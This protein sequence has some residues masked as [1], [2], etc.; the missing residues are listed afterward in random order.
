MNQSFR[1]SSALKDIIGRDLI[2]ND[3]VAIFELVKNSFD[4]HADRVDIAFTGDKI[5]IADNGK[6]MASQ[7][8][9]DR[10]LFVAYS[11][12][13]SGEEDEGLPQD[14][15]DRIS[16]RPGYAGSKGIGRF[17]CDRLGSSLKLYSRPYGS[18]GKVAL[19]DVR[20]ADF[21]NDAK[22]PFGEIPVNLND[23]AHFPSYSGL[24]N[25]K[26]GTILQIDDLRD[27]WDR[28][29]LLKLKSYL[30]KLINPFGVQSDMQIVFH[31]ES[32]LAEDE[33]QLE[34]IDLPDD[35]KAMYSTAREALAHLPVSLAGV[36]NGPVGNL[37]FEALETKTTKLSVRI[38]PEGKVASRLV[39]RGRLI[40]E[41]EE[42]N[43]F[44]LLTGAEIAVDLFYLNRAAK[45]SFK[46]S[47]GVESVGFGN[48][49]LFLNGFRIFPVGEPADDTF[50]LNVRKAQGHSRYLGT[51]EILGRLDI[52]APAEMFRETSSRDAGLI[53]TPRVQA[54]M[55][56]FRRYALVRLERYV[57]DVTWVDKLDA[58]RLDTSG[59]TTEAARARIIDVVANLVQ[60]QKVRLLA[61]ADDLIDIIN[62][63][64]SE[65]ETSMKGLAVVAAQTG[66]A[67][68]LSR[69][70]QARKRYEALKRR[71]KEAR[72]RADAEGE[73]RSQAEARAAEATARADT[74]EARYG[75]EQKRSL[76]LTALSGRE[77]DT[78]V[79]LHHQVV[80]YATSV[81]DIVANNLGLLKRGRTPS[82]EELAADLEQI[83]F[84]NSRI[85]AV[86]RFATQANFRLDADTV[87]E[88]LVQYLSD[89]VAEI[90]SMYA[91]RDFASFD[92]GDQVL[93]TRFRPIDVAIIVD[94][95][96]SNAKRARATHI[97]FAC[98][99]SQGGDL[100]IAVVDD[101]IGIDARRVDRDRIFEKGYSSTSGSGLG[102][103]H[104]SQVL[105][106][107]RG[108]IALDDAIAGTGA[109]F[110]IRI[111][112]PKK[113]TR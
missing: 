13:K 104:V 54:L 76:F 107:L 25:R 90:S 95:L 86:T 87:E 106:A 32:E 50:G 105:S 108:T 17:S 57:V 41:I 98:R 37:I 67:D 59:L 100:E 3:L 56:A 42:D 80:I 64:T 58:D 60:N 51:R 101:G 21:E 15:R 31:C 102:L 22:I 29:K 12:K 109:A 84:Q 70:E 47:M 92:T 5:V 78:L 68:L 83:S 6:G 36:V 39:D 61:Y 72:D 99:K 97:K 46:R 18:D 69:I 20:W 103:Y 10:W 111:P 30:A 85:L 2:T 89:Y 26:N 94:N 81:Q 96:V 55:D 112:R 35:L 79:N 66:N 77:K 110:I 8:I 33:R 24:P 44:P 23:T 14:Y 48:V 40:Y 28:Q 113:A 82:A 27:T 53:E 34:E 7:D 9:L 73:A 11:A 43:A 93:E 65:F 75:E 19:L 45:V 52:N 38:S 88:D 62:E 1:I 71:E 49:F 74:A 16:L 4:A 91:G 63:R